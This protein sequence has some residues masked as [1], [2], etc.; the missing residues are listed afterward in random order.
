MFDA[1]DPIE[2]DVPP[3][4]SRIAEAI[5]QVCRSPFECSSVLTVPRSR[6]ICYSVHLT[7]YTTSSELLLTFY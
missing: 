3:R 1:N 6:V 2:N 4:G 7:I 5:Q